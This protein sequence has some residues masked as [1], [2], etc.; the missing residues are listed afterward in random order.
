M[1]YLHVLTSPAQSES[2][3]RAVKLDL[4]LLVD[5]VKFEEI[6]TMKY[7]GCLHIFQK[8]FFSSVCVYMHHF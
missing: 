7:H 6:D 4:C 8:N 2:G 5:N 3:M 1:K